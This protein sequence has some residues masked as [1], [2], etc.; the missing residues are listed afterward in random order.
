MQHGSG[1]MRRRKMNCG[2]RKK[3]NVQ[4]FTTQRDRV[5]GRQFGVIH[6]EFEAITVLARNRLFRRVSGISSRRL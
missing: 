2:R 3:L 1:C 4:G 6:G 5:C